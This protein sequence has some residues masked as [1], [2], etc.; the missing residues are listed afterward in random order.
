VNA[1]DAPAALLRNL[2]AAGHSLALDVV[3]RSGRSA[4][5]AGVR[6]TAGGRSQFAVVSGGTS[7]LSTS[8]PVLRFGLGSARAIDEIEVRWPWREREIW[9]KPAQ[10]V[11]GRL[12]L[13]EGTG[14]SA[15]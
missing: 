15:P 8:S 2:S 9:T 5:G 7:Y 14:K 3:D 13:S 6:V 12:R 4:V 10:A 11:R 1:L